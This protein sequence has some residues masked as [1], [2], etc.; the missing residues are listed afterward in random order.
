MR[1]NYTL[2]RLYLPQPL[3]GE[4]ALAKEQAHY[5]GTVLRKGVGDE[6]RL[7]NAEDG[8]WAAVVVT[9]AKRA[10]TVRI[11]RQLRA[12]RVVPDIRL[13]FAPIR[14]HRTATILEKATELGVRTIQPVLTERTQFP[15]LKLERS[16]AQIIEAAEQTERLDLPE[17]CEPKAL[18]DAVSDRTLV[19]ADEAGGGQ[20][21]GEADLATPLDLLIGPEGGFSP[22]ERDRLLGMPT[23]VSV[24]LG[25]RI[26]R[27]DT[28]TISLLT[29][30]QARCGDW[31]HI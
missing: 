17:L 31:Q 22:A 14:K 28:A 9:V 27:A 20:L 12:P 25:P 2:P 30:V 21:V 6:V 3:K 1:P 15:K 13:L 16:R 18:F 29:L 10:M 7:F 23:T 19:F 24:T 5:L 4:I 8:E 11:D 26:L